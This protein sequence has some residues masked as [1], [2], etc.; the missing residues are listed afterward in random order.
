MD[1]VF[2]HVL[3]MAKLPWCVH[4]AAVVIAPA[5]RAGERCELNFGQRPLA[6]PLPGYRPLVDPPAGAAAAAW[7]LACLRRLVLSLMG[8]SQGD[9]GG[10]VRRLGTRSQT[11]VGARRAQRRARLHQNGRHFW[12]RMRRLVLSGMQRGV[13]EPG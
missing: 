6:H 9:A 12:G 3:G 1:S 8:D 13:L 10:Q 11:L 5:L 4:D 2:V 7:L